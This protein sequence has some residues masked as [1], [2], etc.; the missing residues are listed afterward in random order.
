MNQTQLKEELHY[1]PETGIFTRLK[2]WGTVKKGDIAGHTDTKFRYGYVRIGLKGKYYQAHRLAFLYMWGYMPKGEVDHI[3]HN[4]SN[5]TWINLRIVTHSENGKNQKKYKSN[6]SSVTGVAQRSS[7]KWRARIYHKG[8]HVHLG[9]W[10]TFKLACTARTNAE[11]KLGFH[12][13]HGK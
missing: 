1:C 2:S 10:D 9:T 8:K 7:G 13:E 3:D 6:T 11:I 4:T 5:N 12:K